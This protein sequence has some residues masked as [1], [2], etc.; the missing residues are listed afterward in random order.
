MKVEYVPVD[1]AETRL[2]NRYISCQISHKEVTYVRAI[3]NY[4]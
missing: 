3:Y 1:W 4:D 2:I